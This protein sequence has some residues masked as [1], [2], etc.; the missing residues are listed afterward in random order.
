MTSGALF[1]ILGKGSSHMGSFRP[2]CAVAAPVWMQPD[3]YI[4]PSH[5]VW[6]WSALPLNW[7]LTRNWMGCRNLSC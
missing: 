7:L 4:Q 5:V 1:A 6:A 2:F 3:K